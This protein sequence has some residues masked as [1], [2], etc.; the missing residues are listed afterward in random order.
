MQH[1][2]GLSRV[3]ARRVSLVMS[4]LAAMTLSL[5]L[6]ARA[7]AEGT[8]CPPDFKVFKTW[9]VMKDNAT[10]Q[11]QVVM[12]YLMKNPLPIMW[13]HTMQEIIRTMYT[14]WQEGETDSAD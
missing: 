6:A 7:H 11:E 10:P 9:L 14:A 4:T 3:R 2:F 12:D 5:V 8:W 13:S 1:G